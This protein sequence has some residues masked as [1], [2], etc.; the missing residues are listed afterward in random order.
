MYE[1]WFSDARA[2]S[3]Y[4]R[5]QRDRILRAADLFIGT[6]YDTGF[7]DVFPEAVS[8]HLSTLVKCSWWSRGGDFGIWEGPS[9]CGLHTTDVAYHGSHSLVS[10]FPRLQLRQ[11][12]MTAAFQRDDG[13]IPHFF[14]PDFGSVDD[15]FDRVDMN[16]QFVLLVCRNYLATG[17]R[18]YAA[19]MWPH[20]VRAMDRT[21]RLD[22]NGDG[23]PD[24]D[25]GRNTYD[26][27]NFSGTSAYISVL[28]L[29]A[30]EAACLLADAC[31]R[32]EQADTWRAMARRGAKA[33]EELL[34]C[35]E[36]YMLWADGPERDECCMTDQLDGALFA[37]LIGLEDFLPDERIRT[38]LD[39]VWRYNYSDENGL[40]NASCPPG[41]R[42]TLHTFRNCQGLANWSGI[43]YLTAAFYMMTGRYDRGL[44]ITENVFDRHRRLGQIWDHAE[45]GDYYYRPMSSWVLMQALSGASL[46]RARK[47]L[48]LKDGAAGGPFRGPWFSSGAYGRIEGDAGYRS[49]TCLC[50]QADV[51]QILVGGGREPACV[52][53][54]GRSVPFEGR[55]GGLAEIV[56]SHLT[57]TAGSTLEI[58]WN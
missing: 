25:A 58:R 56:P 35:G 27:W 20:V 54:N 28:W 6:L 1:N 24:T 16:P 36:Y 55:P 12:R 37:H 51:R 34:W 39:S 33:L 42:F 15:G 3:G 30:L 8:S 22:A 43:E 38:A 41:R 9:S 53:L 26:A 52:A 49:L 57:L 46:D 40:I 10:L 5:Q 21:A 2:V 14:T 23:L 19:D 13:C 7:P 48:T 31:E 11:M 47:R 18:G 29:A 45:C 32:S 4:L 44:K 17:D 50:G